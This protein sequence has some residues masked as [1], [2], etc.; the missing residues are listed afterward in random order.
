ML[1]LAALACNAPSGETP[2]AGNSP[3]VAITAPGT[4]ARVLLGQ[5]LAVES[6]SSHPNGVARVELWADGVKYASEI[7]PDPARKS[8]SVIQKWSASAAGMHT[9]E[10]RVYAPGASTAAAAAQVIVE[11]VA[12]AAQLTATPLPGAADTPAP[13]AMTATP[14]PSATPTVT[15]TPTSTPTAT[16]GAVGGMVLVP[17]GAFTMGRD[18]GAADTKPAHTVTLSDF[19]I[20]RT[21]VTLGQFKGFVAATGYR[22]SAE[23]RGDANN[24]RQFDEA[25]LQNRPVRWMSWFDANEY[26]RWAGKRLPT[27]A[28]WEKAARGTDGRLYPWG[29]DYVAALVPHADAVDVGS[30]ANA[31]PYGALD[32]SGN[33]WEWVLDWYDGGYYWATLNAVN[34]TGPA[35]GQARALRGGGYNNDATRLTVTYRHSGGP[36]GYAPD[37]GFRCAR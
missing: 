34:P 29:N 8:Y 10:V 25:G 5:D 15:G 20:D 2:P 17:G 6:T 11:V 14:S 13:G 28:E 31:S 35:S 7:N 23:Q 12:S 37:H 21:E 16:P 3:N 32:M 1:I 33:T 18:D 26:C 24:W 36:D 27:E 30:L 22:T 19:Y 4:G 9:L